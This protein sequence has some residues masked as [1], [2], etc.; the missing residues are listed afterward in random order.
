MTLSDSMFVLANHIIQ[1]MI[2]TVGELGEKACRKKSANNAALMPDSKQAD[3]AT[4]TTWRLVRQ[5]DQKNMTNLFLAYK[6]T[7]QRTK[8]RFAVL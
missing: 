3:D 1:T 2:A 5:P 4:G 8:C 6:W 7:A